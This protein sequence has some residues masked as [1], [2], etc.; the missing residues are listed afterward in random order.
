MGAG[1]A[2][3]VAHGRR[4]IAQC[5]LRGI[6]ELAVLGQMRAALHETVEAGHVGHSDLDW[7]AITRCQMRAAS[8]VVEWNNSEIATSRSD[9]PCL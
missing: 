4:D 7:I 2:L 5:S 3:S 8:K 1:D 6:E 9:S